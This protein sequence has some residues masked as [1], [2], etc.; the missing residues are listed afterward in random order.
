M[1][2]IPPLSGEKLPTVQAQDKKLNIHQSSSFTPWI[3]TGSGSSPNKSY[4]D[5]QYENSGPDTMTLIEQRLQKSPDFKIISQ[6]EAETLEP[7][8]EP[9]GKYQSEALSDCYKGNKTHPT[10]VADSYAKELKIAE[11]ESCYH[12]NNSIIQQPGMH[13]DICSHET[14]PSLFSKGLSVLDIKNILSDFANSKRCH[15]KRKGGCSLGDIELL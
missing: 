11:D 10:N 15:L 5:M 1:S 13:T 14:R 9:I 8:L 2:V 3:C 12:T 6:V 4:G 7:S